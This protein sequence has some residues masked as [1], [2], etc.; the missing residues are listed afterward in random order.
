VVPALFSIFPAAHR[1]SPLRALP[2]N[3][4]AADVL[5]ERFPTLSLASVPNA[6]GMIASAEALVE[7]LPSE[8]G[9]S[10]P[11]LEMMSQVGR[12]FP[13][14]PALRWAIAYCC[15]R[16][17][18]GPAARARALKCPFLNSSACS[19][20]VNFSAERLAHL[21]AVLYVVFWTLVTHFGRGKPP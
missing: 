6:F 12:R 11:W 17:D 13:L 4:H 18:R 14:S 7:A 3:P 20:T 19:V 15:R 21:G 1:P 8:Q 2:E 10:P 16:D 9:V 5:P